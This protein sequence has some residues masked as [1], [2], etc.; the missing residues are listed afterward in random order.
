MNNRLSAMKVLKIIY[1]HIPFKKQLFTVLRLLP[2]PERIYRHLHFRGRYTCRF[3]S[4]Q[5]FK[6]YHWGNQV[7]ND[8]FWAGYG[9]HWEATSLR[10]WAAMCAR[11]DV[12][13]DIGANTGVYALAA[14]AINPSAK[15]FAF[16]PVERVFQKL[17]VNAQLNDEKISVQQLAV[18]NFSG[19]IEI[20]DA[21]T[22][23]VYSA[24]VRPDLLSKSIPEKD[25]ICTRVPSIRMD[26][27]F[28]KEAISTENK[29]IVK[30]DV[31][32]HEPEVF[33]GFGKAIS[34]YRPIFLVE[35][36]SRELGNKI[37][38]ILEPLSYV[39]FSIEESL[40]VERVRE[41]GL[42]DRNYLAIP[43][44][45]PFIHELEKSKK[46]SDWRLG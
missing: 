3:G 33:E 16:K 27:F 32:M 24:S 6:I 30:I 36:L 17:R 2:L 37:S 44:E 20:Y 7:E 12:V 31:E 35:V 45:H 41:L 23:H 40:A 22:E 28:K 39:Y 1:G 18:S 11:A 19:E 10:V 46:H 14:Q 4:K 42:L 13:F 21:N 26:D 9:N 38:E 25:L 34:E 29:I 8:L 5:Q 15:I 43:V